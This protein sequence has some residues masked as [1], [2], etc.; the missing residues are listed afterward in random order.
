MD[1][2]KPLPTYI[3]GVAVVLFPAPS[4]SV[5]VLPLGS[6]APAVNCPA[7]FPSC[8]GAR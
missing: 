7:A 1:E 8:S 2:C 5:N 6:G 4:F 3:A